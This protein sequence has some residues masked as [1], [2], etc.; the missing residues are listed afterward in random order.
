MRSKATQLTT[1]HGDGKHSVYCRCQGREW[2]TSLRSTAKVVFEVGFSFF[3]GKSTEI[4]VNHHLLMF[5]FLNYSFRSQLVYDSLAVTWGYV[6]P[7]YPGETHPIAPFL[8]AWTVNSLI[9]VK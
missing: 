4:G 3:K 6:S 9:L 7:F 2:E 1:A 8:P 5:L